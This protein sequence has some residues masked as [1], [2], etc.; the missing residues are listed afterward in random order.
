MGKLDERELNAPVTSCM[1]RDYTVLQPTFTIEQALAS[2]RSQSVSEKIIYFY[3][4]DE[5]N[6]LLGVVPTRRLL[7]S[8]SHETIA[9]IMV[10]RVIS[11]PDSM[12][13]L[14]A[15]EFFVMHRLLA[16]PIVDR[17]GKLLGVVDAA[18]FTD[19]VFDLSE[20]QAGEDVFQMIGVKIA[21]GR[22]AAPWSAFRDRF[23]WLLCNICGGIGCAFIAGF[24]EKLL[25]NVIILALFIPVVLTLAEAVS[26]QSMT[27]TLQ[28][29]RQER[30]DW[31]LLWRSLR[32]ELMI[33]LF[34]GIACGSIVGLVAMA[35]KHHGTVALAIGMSICLAV[36]T[37]CVLGVLLPAAVR[38]ARGDPRIAS[39]PLVLATA[40]IATLLFYFNLCGLM[41]R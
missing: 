24:Y 11:I 22:R 29:M 4:T 39:G 14:D 36:L 28:A 23:P 15:C 38:A 10:D 8:D 16:F 30:I 12:T 17:E 26:M 35:W 18:V 27:L 31:K 25:D 41:L 34:L 9:R 7:M 3:V 37:A 13:V 20:R 40:D 32:L 33:A 21:R 6:K 19:E 1:R 5:S 2:L